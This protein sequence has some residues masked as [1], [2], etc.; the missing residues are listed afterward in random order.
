M[1]LPIIRTV[2]QRH[3]A[4]CGVACLAMLTGVSYEEAL[5]AATNKPETFCKSGLFPADLKRAAKALGYTLRAKKRFDLET[6]TGI[7]WVL[8]PTFASP[9]LV[10]LW[11]GLIIDTDGG[12]YKQDVYMAVNEAKATTL[13]VAEKRGE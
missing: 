3:G 4:D 11:E 10:V 8:V 1:D 9:H 7:L 13:F 6:D 5:V 2:R 12:L